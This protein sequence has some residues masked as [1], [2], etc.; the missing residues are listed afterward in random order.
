[1]KERGKWNNDRMVW[2]THLQ[3]QGD[4]GLHTVK[5]KKIRTKEILPHSGCEE[6][7]RNRQKR[8]GTGT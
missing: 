7:Y 4:M 8:K 6:K 3:G 2:D 1:M 5:I